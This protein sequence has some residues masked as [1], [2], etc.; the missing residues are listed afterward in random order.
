MV[1]NEIKNIL[2]SNT[3]IVWIYN[4][5]IMFYYKYLTT[6]KKIITRRFK[7]YFN[8]DINLKNPRTYNEKLQ[9]LKLND[10]N[11]IYSDMVDKYE[12][13][14]TISKLIGEEYLIPLIGVYD[15]FDDIN[16]DSLP[17]QFV[18]KAT[19]DSGGVVICKNKNEFNIKNAKKKLNKSLKNN[20]Y[21]YS[22]E[23]P[24]K[25]IKPRIICEKFM[26]DKNELDIRDYKFMCFNGDPKLVQLH[27]NRSSDY[28]LDFYDINWK[29]T[30][31]AQG[32]P[33][34]NIIEKKPDDLDKMISI[35]KIL[36]AGTIFSRIDLYYINK[37]IY[38]G[39]ITYYPTSGL[40]PFNDERYDVMLGEWIDINKINSIK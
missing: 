34:S 22:R 37:K 32:V 25:N 1:N 20:Y 38:F 30:D 4:K 8:K 2:K 18:L 40:T 27:K 10:R 11:P 15:S 31:I 19:H 12:V 9:W 26:I 24:Y 3:F 36:S 14:K 39:E 5:L 35:A 6:D 13:R 29:K 16:F 21:Y 28:T 17:D 23:W 33:I 7:K